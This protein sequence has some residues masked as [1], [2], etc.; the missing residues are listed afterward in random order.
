MFSLLW[1]IL[2]I[3][4]QN[5]KPEHLHTRLGT[6]ILMSC[7]KSEWQSKEFCLI[8]RE[9]AIGINNTCTTTW[10]TLRKPS[11][12]HCLVHQ[13]QNTCSGSTLTVFLLPHCQFQVGHHHLPVMTCFKSGFVLHGMFY[14]CCGTLCFQVCVFTFF[15]AVT[16][17]NKNAQKRTKSSP[18]SNTNNL[19][20]HEKFNTERKQGRF[21][22]SSCS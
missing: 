14:V 21:K 12:P 11:H 10:T 15:L 13:A 6:S 17:T 2:S 8:L 19:G 1:G 7:S 9:L 16:G 22:R 3:K 18:N 4:A 5:P 20:F